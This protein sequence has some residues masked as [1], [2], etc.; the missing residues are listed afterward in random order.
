MA[1]PTRVYLDYNATAPLCPAAAA[2]MRAAMDRQ[3]GNPSSAH[4][5]GR[6]AAAVLDTARQRLAEAVGA[7]PAQVVFT[8]GGT[9]AVN[10][11]I[12]GVAAHSPGP[13]RIVATATDHVCVLETARALAAEGWE[14]VLLPVD[15]DGRIDLEAAGTALNGGAACCVTHWANNE[16]GVLQDLAALGAACAAAGVPLLVDSVQAL[17]K[18]PI[19]FASGPARALALSAHKIGGPPGIGALVVD[20]DL[21]WAPL[22]RG[23]HQE[24]DRRAGTEAVI[25][26]AGFGAAA[27]AAAEGAP[28]Y[29]GR[30]GPRRD[31]LVA[32]LRTA[33]PALIEY[34]AG[35]PRVA[36]TATVRFPGWL[37]ETL[38]QR[39]DLEGLAV[40]TGAACA[41][42]AVEPSHVLR[43]LGVGERAA[44]EAIRFSLGP[45][46]SDAD[47]ATALAILTRVGAEWGDH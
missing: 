44:R 11:M 47:V 26:A 19:R 38:V 7:M 10:T 45:G 16:T 36:N 30:V 12:R 17:G 1:A 31:A 20:P 34:G 18:L 8:S 33:V 37:A 24:A 14:T 2:A 32:G 42:G 9:E 43:A 6:A 27:V 35:A 25:A 28:A 5:E 21:D 4:A 40:G 22:L 41:A 23:G 13:R 29:A 15:G 3:L 46:T 39:L